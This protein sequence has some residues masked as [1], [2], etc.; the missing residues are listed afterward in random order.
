MMASSAS[1]NRIPMRRGDSKVGTEKPDTVVHGVP[2][3][4]HRLIVE[5]IALA[6]H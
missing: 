2:A 1:D 3:Q 6:K 4:A 5:A